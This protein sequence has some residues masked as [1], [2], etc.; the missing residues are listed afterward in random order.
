MPIT[1]SKARAF[2][3]MDDSPI[4]LV[5]YVSYLRN[6]PSQLSGNRIFL[7][8]AYTWLKFCL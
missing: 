2:M 7:L 4:S 1:N 6:N 3:H 8:V 5:T